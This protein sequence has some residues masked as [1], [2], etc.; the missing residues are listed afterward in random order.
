MH[1]KVKSIVHK[2]ARAY[3]VVPCMTP[4]RGW[5]EEEKEREKEE[6]E[7]KDKHV[8]GQRPEGNKIKFNIFEPRKIRKYEHRIDQHGPFYDH[9]HIMRSKRKS[10]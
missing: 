6:E 2:S 9:F 4:K 1:S 10:K 7:E 8:K 5:K 3:C